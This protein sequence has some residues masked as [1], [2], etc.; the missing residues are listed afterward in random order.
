MKLFKNET[1]HSWLIRK[2]VF[3]LNLN[4][5]YVILIKGSKKIEAE[6]VV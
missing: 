5:E 1:S 3:E 6:E 4:D 2:C